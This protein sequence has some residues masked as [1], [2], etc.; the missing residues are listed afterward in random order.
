MIGQRWSFS[1]GIYQAFLANRYWP[2]DII[3]YIRINSSF[4]SFCRSINHGSLTKLEAGRPSSL[5]PFLLP[6]NFGDIVLSLAFRFSVLAA[7]LCL[8]FLCPRSGFRF[9]TVPHQRVPVLFGLEAVGRC[10]V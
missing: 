1:I 10:F 7:F 9:S 3:V 6:N 4:V 2:S 5:L 8:H